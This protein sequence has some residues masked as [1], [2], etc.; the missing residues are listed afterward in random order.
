MSLERALNFDQ[1]HFQKLYTNES[2]IMP[3]LQ[4]YE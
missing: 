1:K 4:I 3:C 2:L